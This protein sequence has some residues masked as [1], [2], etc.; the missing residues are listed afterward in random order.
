MNPGG[1]S[2]LD[3]EPIVKTVGGGLSVYGEPL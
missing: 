1:E 3:G 2:P